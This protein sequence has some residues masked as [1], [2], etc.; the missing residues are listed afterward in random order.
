MDIHLAND[1]DGVAAAEEILRRFGVRSLFTTA[2]DDP[3]TRARAAAAGPVGFIAKPYTNEKIATALSHPGCDGAA[4]QR[5]ERQDRKR[6]GSGEGVSVRG[7]LGG[8]LILKK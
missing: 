6:E 8:W 4:L 7:E 2:H 3:A 5:G 1:S